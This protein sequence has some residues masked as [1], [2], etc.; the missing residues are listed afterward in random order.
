MLADLYF[1]VDF[2]LLTLSV[3]FEGTDSLNVAPLPASSTSFKN[4]EILGPIPESE[5]FVNGIFFNKPPGG[6][7]N[8]K[9]ELLLL[10]GGRAP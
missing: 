7:N 9:Q 3:N 10:E 6:S 4:L 5:T 1:L 2:Y 8:Q